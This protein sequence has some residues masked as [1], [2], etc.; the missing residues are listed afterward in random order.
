MHGQFRPYL[1][2]AAVSVSCGCLC[3]LWLICQ[4]WLFVSLD[5]G[6]FYDR[7][8]G[9]FHAL[10]A[11]CGHMGTSGSLACCCVCCEIWLC[12]SVVAYVPVVAIC[13]FGS[14]SVLR[15]R[16]GRVSCS[17]GLL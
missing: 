12:L 9:A 1:S 11:W 5:L 13:Q 10:G 16:R 8:E 14:G 7:V 17:W 15:Q 3:Q 6:M 2:A 4:L